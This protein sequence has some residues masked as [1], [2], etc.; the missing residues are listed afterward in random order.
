MEENYRCGR[1]FFVFLLLE[2]KE[3]CDEVAQKADKN[4][5]RVSINEIYPTNHVVTLGVNEETDIVPDITCWDF[6]GFKKTIDDQYLC[7]NK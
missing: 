2:L 3:Y 5:I 6:E 7:R 4:H 1:Y